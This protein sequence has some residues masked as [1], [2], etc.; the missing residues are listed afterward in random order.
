MAASL[1]KESISINSYIYKYPR[2]IALKMLLAPF[3]F[4]RETERKGRTG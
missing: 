1:E 4:F 2:E 3:L